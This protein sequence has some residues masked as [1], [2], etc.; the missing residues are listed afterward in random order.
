MILSIYDYP[1]RDLQIAFRS[2]GKVTACSC[3]SMERWSEGYY[4]YVWIPLEDLEDYDIQ[5]AVLLL[6]EGATPLLTI[7]EET[8]NGE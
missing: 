3:Q 2:A 1:Y 4:R 7:Q 5:A 6:A 8:Q